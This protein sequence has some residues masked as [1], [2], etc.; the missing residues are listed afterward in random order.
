MDEP[1]SPGEV[2]A[3]RFRVVRRIAQGGM[4]VV[5]E[6]VD[7][8][9]GRRIALKCARVGHGRHLTPEVRLATEISHPNIC[10]IYEIH[11][12]NTAQGPLEFFT[13]EFLEGET[14]SQRLK[15]GPAARG[16]AQTIAEQICAGLAEAHRHGIIH[17]DLKS[18]NIILAK[19]P[20]GTLRAVITDF[21]LA[22]ASFTRD[23]SGG[24][25]GYRAPE[26]SGGAPTTVASDI[27]AL[28]VI[29]YELICGFRP[30][31]RARMD[32]ST[33]TQMPH[34]VAVDAEPGHQEAPALKSKWDKVLKKCLQTDP[35]KRYASVDEVIRA[36][37]PSRRLRV[38][39]SLASALAVEVAAALATYQQTTAPSEKVRLNVTG[40]S[41]LIEAVR[42]EIG[43][44]H[45]SR[46]TAFSLASSGAT[47]R[48]EVDADSHSTAN[49]KN[50]VHGV[51]VDLRSGAP[52]VEWSGD[53]DEE[54]LRYAP[55]ALAGL[56]SWGI[57]LTALRTQATM[58]SGAEAYEH[59]IALLK[60]DAKL[61][62]AIKQLQK[63]S[64]LD[65]DSALPFAELAEACRRKYFLT[66]NDRWEQQAI[67]WLDQAE[68]RNTDCA[69]V[70]RIAGLLEFDRNRQQEAIARELRAT[71]F[72]PPHPD[73]FRRLGQFYE[74]NGQYTEALQ[75]YKEAQ[76]IAPQDVRVYQDLF[77]LYDR[78]S[79]SDEAVKALQ[80][81][82]EIAPQRSI[83]HT[84]LARTYQ[85]Q[86][87]FAEAEDELLT[88]VARETSAS[89]L[90]QLG[91]VVMYEKRDQDAIPLLVRS[92]KLNDKEAFTWLYLGLANQRTGH[93]AD[94]RTAFAR[95]L[96][97]AEQ[98]VVEQARSGYHHSLLAYFCAQAGQRERAMVEAAQGLQL[99]PRDS[100]VLWMT[101][102]TYERAGKRDIA[103]K[104]LEAAP[105]NLLE[106]LRRWPEASSLT[107]DDR[108]SKLLAKKS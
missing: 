103:L 8:K 85:D 45:N 70:H 66:R 83:L 78:R 35:G 92:A 20:D 64:A 26:L 93:E 21:G 22:R 97:L 3:D 33:V 61:D 27:Y 71:E 41:G 107:A 6:A 87:R 30:D 80:K 49:G 31:E 63:A 73:A 77:N 29:L 106:D 74:R 43:E 75:A 14:L 32:A 81:G 28:G 105:R 53:Y 11:T 69:E 16:E 25:A 98:N 94:A 86:G 102:L 44:L 12:A 100:V 42:R 95:G 72:E 19:K 96:A 68:L 36:L 65:P 51:L 48:L 4:G 56:V 59:G 90:L 7:E 9:L 34:P 17:G 101:A 84:L 40:A 10:K 79:N 55:V 39:L 104:T 46:K 82:I 91:H 89:S 62:E 50:R 38:V 54:Q 58:Q 52:V 47:H 60:D 15:R 76:R 37:G 99:A 13:M 5:Y 67:G 23:V 88:L 2:L 24:T 1:L 57:H 108:F 18:G